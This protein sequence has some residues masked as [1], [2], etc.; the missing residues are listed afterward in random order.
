M[1]K[2]LK[3]VLIGVAIVF[4]AV[5]AFTLSCLLGVLMVHFGVFEMIGL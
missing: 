3:K 1:V 4:G 5:V 2:L